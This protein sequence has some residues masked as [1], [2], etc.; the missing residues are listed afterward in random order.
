MKIDYKGNTSQNGTP[1]PS[2]PI[3]INVVSGDN[4]IHICG[5][6]L[7]DKDN[8]NILNA[9]DLVNNYKYR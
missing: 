5:K 3:P 2:S 4:T 9:C 6:N 8:A 7:F 1:T